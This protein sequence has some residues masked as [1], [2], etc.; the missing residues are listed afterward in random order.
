MTET[1]AHG[2]SSDNTQQELSNEYLKGFDGPF[3]LEENSLSL[4]RVNSIRLLFF[5][6]LNVRPM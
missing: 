1:L 4:R 3:A 2:Y 6:L 5:T